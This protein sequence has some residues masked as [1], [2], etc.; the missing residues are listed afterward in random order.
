[1][2]NGVVFSAY[3]WLSLFFS[4]N[5]LLFVFLKCLHPNEKKNLKSSLEIGSRIAKE[6]FQFWSE[7]R[8]KLHIYINTCRTIKITLIS[9]IIKNF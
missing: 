3:R 8:Y 2:P 4:F 1:M 6:M 7:S 9:L 5:R